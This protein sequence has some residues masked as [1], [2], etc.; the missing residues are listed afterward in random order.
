MKKILVLTALLYPMFASALLNHT[1]LAGRYK[2]VHSQ[3]QMTLVIADGKVHLYERP[4]Q[5]EDDVYDCKSDNFRIQ[6]NIFETTLACDHKGSKPF[7][8]DLS[9]IDPEKLAT[10]VNVPVNAFGYSFTVLIQ[11]I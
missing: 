11:K 10:G 8:A 4:N 6:N 3:I 1:N 2:V 9:G 7:R 5:P